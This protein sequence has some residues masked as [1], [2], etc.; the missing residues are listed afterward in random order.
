M[1]LFG[2]LGWSLRGR[3]NLRQD[4]RG[5]QAQEY[6]RPV[7]HQGI[8]RPTQGVRKEAIRTTVFNVHLI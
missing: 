7:D 8:L 4:R 6:V 3:G 5:D 1:I 2:F